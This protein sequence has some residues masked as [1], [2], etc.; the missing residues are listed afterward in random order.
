MSLA[1][2]Y[3][4]TS[5]DEIVGQEHLLN[6]NKVLRQLIENDGLIHTF[7]YGPPGCGKTTLARVIA[8][9]LQRPFM[10]LMPPYSKSMR[11]ERYS[12]AMPML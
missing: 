3:R 10:S 8:K 12:K 6:P 5:L 1:L 2:K 7:F 9:I 11:C 4:P